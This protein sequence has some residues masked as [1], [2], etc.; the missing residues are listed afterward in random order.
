MQ[1][2]NLKTFSFNNRTY[3][4]EAS[5]K[6]AQSI[7]KKA[8][9]K[10]IKRE[11][12][13]Q[14]LGVEKIKE[15]NEKRRITTELNK[16]F[17]LPVYTPEY[18]PLKKKETREK[19]LEKFNN[20][21]YNVTNREE[22][23]YDQ[24]EESKYKFIKKEILNGAYTEI[25]IKNERFNK[26][27][28]KNYLYNYYLNSK[29]NNQ[30]EILE[31]I[32]FLNNLE[33]MIYS[34]LIK[35][36]IYENNKNTKTTIQGAIIINFTFFKKTKDGFIEIERYFHSKSSEVLK[37]QN[38]IKEFSKKNVDLFFNRLVDDNGGSAGYFYK[39]NEITLIFAKRRKTKAG[40][41]IELPK[42]IKDKNACVNIKNKNDN[43]CLIWCLLAKKYYDTIKSKDKNELYHYKKYFDE[44][45]KPKDINYPIDIQHDIPK[46]EKLNDI[47]INVYQYDKNFTKLET[48]YNNND[49]NKNVITLLL[50]DEINKDGTINEHLV[51]IKDLSRLLRVD[52]KH[53]KRFWCYQCL[54]SSYKTI[55]LL[56]E[57]HNLCFNNES[58]ST[59]LPSKT[60][61]NKDGV[62][63]ENPN[64]KIKFKNEQNKIMH[65]F[66]VFLDF[67]ST[68]T[69]V[70]NK[71]G[72]N[73]EQYQ[74][75]EVNSCG[76][77][78]NC[79]NDNLS[80]PIKIINN[81]N[82]E[83]VL[84]ETIETLEEYAKY[85]YDI[86][87]NEKLK[88][89]SSKKEKLSNKNK[90]FLPVYIH[91][92]KNYDGHFIMNSISKYGYKSKDEIITAIPNNEE[93]YISFSKKIKV[94]EYKDKD[95][96]IKPILFEIRFLDTFAFMASS[97]SNLVDNLHPQAKQIEE[98]VK[99]FNETYDKQIDKNNYIDIHLKTLN[100][101]H[102]DN[103]LKLRKIYKNTSNYFKDDNEFK[104]MITKGVY[105]YDFIDNYNKMYTTVL[106][107]KDKFYSQLNDS[108]C[109]DK[110]YKI[111]KT[112]WEQFKCNKFL[113]Y[114]N[115]YLK[116][117]VLLLSDIW[118]NFRK[119][120]YKIYELDT[121]YYYTAPGLSWDA[122][123]KHKSDETKGEFFIELLTDND[124]YLF[125][126]SG[127]RGGLSQ[128]TK[129]YA[130]ANNKYM[131]NYNKDLL[132]EYI[133]YLDANNLYGYSMTQYLPQK[134]FKWNKQNW[135]NSFTKFEDK[136]NYYEN[137][138]KILNI[139][140]D[141]KIGYTF[142]VNLHYPKELHNLHNNYPLAPENKEIKKEWLN[143]WQKE[144]YNESNIKKLITNFHD[145]IN[146]VVNYRILKLY[147]E[148]G[149]KITK[150]NRVL[151]Y[152]Q[153]NFME[154]Y[155]MKNTNERKN[156]K[157]DF[158]K[159]FYKLMNNSVY[160]KTMENVRN[161]ISFVLVSSEKKALN[162]RNNYK[163][164]TT[165]NDNLVGVHLCKKQIT[166]NKPIFIGQTV[167]DQSKFLMYDFHYNFMLKKI[168]RKNIDLLF[169]DTDS[170]CYHI[171]NEDPFEIIKNNKNLFDLSDYPKDHELYD[172]INK[173]V[174]AKFKNESIK[175]IY[176]FVGLRSKLYSYS[177]DGEDND[178][179]KCKG[180]KKY[181]VN[182]KLTLN[183]YK[184]I[185]NNRNTHSEKQNGFISDKHEI[186]TQTQNKI[187]LSA[188][189]DKV[190]ISDNNIDTYNIGHYKTLKKNI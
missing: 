56:E 158:E 189:D 39:I 187:C 137:V 55:E 129:R 9:N 134:D 7:Y 126:E 85:S 145:K 108:E 80:K 164:I 122:F 105:P 13:I 34:E 176:E 107:S 153:D 96:E 50:V 124:M 179:K 1:N 5:L 70:E 190:F 16:N 11:K 118:E 63:I 128:I 154:S 101:I 102:D 87:K 4:N 172:P 73:S 180:V 110:D 65:P 150:V 51:W 6:R 155:I 165:F 177:V 182:K 92:L 41:F 119:T 18:Q 146:Y 90:N 31:N 58:I 103:M 26:K 160:G 52:D 106:P 156:A 37:S 83:E 95:G 35:K 135:V 140:D 15:I 181:V 170:L 22:K 17:G 61:I 142:D 46:F 38:Q 157:N 27:L 28:S 77:K 89:K 8:Q 116:S 84:K 45:I 30:R 151:Q 57:H 163:K 184:E 81:R 86:I 68:L 71:I 138:D 147:L 174:I 21:I 43:Y 62:E 178:H 144:D 132:N 64:S 104:L 152:E 111:A 136:T 29:S 76:I 186:Y 141:N 54:N 20:K 2:N 143:E 94:G 115:I 49:R 130:K 32:I 185:L 60:I 123:L 24:N 112:V 162:M 88:N 48:L 173:K 75:H 100:K 161:R 168:K 66:N 171:K 121:S 125:F 36:F 159:D 93:R 33:N 14:K 72:E 12:N 25:I 109:D 169:T 148:L 167:L 40:T 99:N 175:Q 98:L 19:R 74:K 120:C 67:E 78:F 23:I 139:P 117:D 114:H 183:L 97:L 113:D 69:N 188:T 44:I 82:S 166:L 10:L 127:I 79:I 131:S 59:K 149:L 3:K 42:K 133:L 91:N 47:K 53:E